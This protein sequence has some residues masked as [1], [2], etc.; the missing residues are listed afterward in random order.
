MNLNDIGWGGLPERGTPLR[1]R[2]CATYA[3]RSVN[4]LK[5]KYNSIINGNFIIEFIEK[6]WK[7]QA[8]KEELECSPVRVTTAGRKA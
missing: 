4:P 6:R 2:H 8:G 5:C 3:L 7:V 1:L